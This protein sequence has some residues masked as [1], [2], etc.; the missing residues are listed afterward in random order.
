MNEKELMKSLIISKQIIDRLD[1]PRPRLKQL[2]MIVPEIIVPVR[3]ADMKLYEEMGAY[4]LQ[5]VSH[6]ERSTHIKFRDNPME[7]L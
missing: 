5:D 3:F 6:S 4:E 7:V 1:P 2:E